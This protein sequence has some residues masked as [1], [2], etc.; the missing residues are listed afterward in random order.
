MSK[1]LGQLLT[2]SKRTGV[3]QGRQFQG[4]IYLLTLENILPDYIKDEDM[5]KVLTE[6]EEESNRITKEVL[7][8]V[9]SG[10]IEEMSMRVVYYVE[11][12]RKKRGMP[13]YE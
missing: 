6:I 1:K 11:Q 13:S 10:D 7:D 2:Q 12:I 3:D 5:G 9:P 8:S 4:A